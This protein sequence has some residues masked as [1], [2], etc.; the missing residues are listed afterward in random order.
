MFFQPCWTSALSLIPSSLMVCFLKVQAFFLSLKT[1]LNLGKRAFSA[2]IKEIFGEISPWETRFRSIILEMAWVIPS[3]P[4]AIDIP[5][6]GEQNPRTAM[7]RRYIR[8]ETSNSLVHPKC[9]NCMIMRRIQTRLLI[10]QVALLT[11]K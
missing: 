5:N 11:Q 10:L 8:I 7:R 1:P 6:G 3:G 2:S 9:M 4:A